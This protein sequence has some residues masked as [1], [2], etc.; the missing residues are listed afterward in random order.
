MGSPVS[1]IETFPGSIWGA[2]L[3]TAIG[4]APM[5]G[6]SSQNYGEPFRLQGYAWDPTSRTVDNDRSVPVLGDGYAGRA[7]AEFHLAVS[8]HLRFGLRVLL[9]PVALPGA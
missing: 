5:Y 1:T 2:G 3:V 8:P 4:D 7:T 6:S 9:S